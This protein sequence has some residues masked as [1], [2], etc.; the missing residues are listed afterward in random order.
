ML[1]GARRYLGERKL[2]AELW[3]AGRS[4]WARGI[5]LAYLL[6]LG[7]RHILEPTYRS[8]FAGITL[9]FHEMGHLVFAA[10][11]DTMQL[12]GGSV[13]QVLVPLVAALYLLFRQGDYFG[14]AVG[15]VWLA[16]SLWELALYIWDAAR[17]ELPLVGFSDDPQHDWGTLLTR[18]QLLNSCDSIAFAVRAL[19]LLI[20]LGSVLLGVWLLWTMFRDRAPYAPSG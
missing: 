14:L 11:G 16:S 9:A 17:E 18:W 7:V 5:L 4:P 12:L 1:E 8:W 13:L 15:G 20:W 2:D 3:A 19:A 6:Y 10:L